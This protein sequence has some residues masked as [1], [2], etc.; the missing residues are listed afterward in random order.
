V[1]QGTRVS[2]VPTTAVVLRV[3][4]LRDV[5]GFD[6]TLR[7]GEDVDLVWRL[8]TAGW[9]CRYEP[10][11]LV[12]HRPRT[13]L[14]AMID[15]RI[16]YGTSAAPLEARHPGALAPVR[17]GRWS[18]AVWG[19]ATVN[20]PA[21]AAIAA[22]STRFALGPTTFVPWHDKVRI[23]M[24]A[25]AHAGRLVASAITRPWWPVAVAAALVSRR[26]RRAVV[27]AAAVPIALDWRNRR[28]SLD[29]IRYAAL[30]IVDDVSYGTGVWIGA[31]RHR[32]L[33]PLVPRLSDAESA[34]R[35]SPR[36]PQQ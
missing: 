17:L 24:T 4:A 34:P 18:A 31:A 6:E 25:H 29:Q 11:S 14:A 32:T 35:P 26:A 7:F 19:V 9:R 16:G 1:R 33:T 2:Y 36:V 28:P 3:D 30:H 5:R 13:T 21:A 27:L 20:A 8:D 10:A 12:H 15:Q 23:V 22:L